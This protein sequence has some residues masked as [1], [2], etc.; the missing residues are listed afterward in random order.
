MRRSLPAHVQAEGKRS[1]FQFDQVFPMHSTQEEVYEQVAAPMVSGA[2]QRGTPGVSGSPRRLPALPLQGRWTAST[3]ASLRM[4][5]QASGATCLSASLLSQGSHV[6]SQHS[7]RCSILHLQAA[8]R[9]TPSQAARTLPSTRASCRACLKT[10]LLPCCP[11][12]PALTYGWCGG[13]H[14]HSRVLEQTLPWPPSQSY[15]EIYK[16]VVYD[17]IMPTTG[18]LDMYEDKDRGIFITGATECVR[19]SRPPTGRAAAHTEPGL[20][21]PMAGYLCAA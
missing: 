19:F 9:H 4:G 8:A 6:R 21:L 7:T 13:C 5:R 16:E 11:A 15:V 3:P 12:R 14:V 17:L 20:V 10:C 2:A 1:T 18:S